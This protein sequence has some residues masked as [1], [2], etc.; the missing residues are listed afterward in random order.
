MS[1]AENFIV[2]QLRNHAPQDRMV[3]IRG[4]EAVLRCPWHAGG[5]ERNPSLG[6][7][8]RPHKG[9]P[10]GVFHCFTCGEHGGWNKL[11]EKIGLRKITKAGAREANSGSALEWALGTD[12][13][14]VV[15]SSS[16][17][18]WPPAVAWRGITGDTLVRFGARRAVIG[19]ESRMYLPVT[20][21]GEEVGGVWC[22]LERKDKKEL[23]YVNTRG[24]WAHTYFL[25]F[26][27]AR[28]KSLRNQ[29]LW[30][31]EGPRDTMNVAQR[32]GRVVG[33]LGANNAKPGKIAYVEE[34][35][36]PMVIVATDPDPA[37][38][39]AA[40]DVENLLRGKYPLRRLRMKEGKDPADLT[41]DMIE[42]IVGRAMSGLKAKRK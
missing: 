18:T 34:I 6:V 26:D 3:L 2:D 10:A 28:Q 17:P 12:V 29:P 15:L 30:I 4:E 38:D 21:Y 40:S 13:G 32:G 9:W 16:M 37:G 31:V 25:G 41:D 19:R 42:K 36:P 33:L 35:D 22:K 23:A 24:E 8:I 39:K 14:H 7:L 11:A 27:Q 5:Q 1:D 20:C